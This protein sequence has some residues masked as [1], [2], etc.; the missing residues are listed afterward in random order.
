MLRL[1]PDSSTGIPESSDEVGDGAGDF[2]D[3]KT[4]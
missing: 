1:M 4:L 2:S 3:G